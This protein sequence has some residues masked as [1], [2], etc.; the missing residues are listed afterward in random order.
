ME[1]NFAKREKELQILIESGGDSGN[2]TSTCKDFNETM[3]SNALEVKRY[4]EAQLDLKNREIKKFK[5]EFDSI[6]E[7]LYTLS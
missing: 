4:Y 5:T 2:L 6:L 3:P 7:L 1:A